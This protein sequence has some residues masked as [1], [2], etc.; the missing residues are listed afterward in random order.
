MTDF[1]EALRSYN[2]ALKESFNNFKA[3]VAKGQPQALALNKDFN[4]FINKHDERLTDEGL[5]HI[6]SKKHGTD[7][8]EEWEDKADK[9]LI[10]NIRKGNFEAIER[11]ND[12]VDANKNEIDQYKFEQFIATKQI[13]ENKE[14]RDSEGF[15]YYNDLLVDCSKNG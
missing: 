2:T 3:K 1:N 11:Y 6:L 8:F 5:F 9:N 14:W 15:K 7:R 10:S 13:K 12:L 4:K